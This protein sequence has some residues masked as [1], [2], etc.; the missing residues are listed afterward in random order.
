MTRRGR[1][2]VS[3][4]ILPINIR[5]QVVAGFDF[6]EP[7]F[8]DPGEG[9][10]LVQGDEAEQMV[11]DAP[12]G[13][14]GAGFGPENEGPVAGLGEEQF[15]GGL[16]QGAGLEAFGGWKA[17]GEIGHAFLG[18]LQVRMDPLVGF[19]EPDAPIPFLAPARGAGRG[20]LVGRVLFQI[21]RG[22]DERDV[23]LLLAQFA[24]EEIDEL[25]AFIPPM[26]EELGIVRRDDD[27]GGGRAAARFHGPDARAHP[28]NAGHV[29]WRRPGRGR[30]DTLS[31]RRCR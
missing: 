16:A 20:D 22:G 6:A 10:L 21:F 13:V 3:S 11:F 29:R 31:F 24:N 26:A 27:G 7:V 19:V 17:V 18:D 14:F 9:K 28:E 25:G 4:P 30:V 8:I 2:F 1:C 15:A 5:E 23:L 12:A